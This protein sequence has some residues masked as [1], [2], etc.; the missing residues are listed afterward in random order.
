M[1]VVRIVN[2]DGRHG[3]DTF[4]FAR[5]VLS[6]LAAGALTPNSSAAAVATA[7]SRRDADRRTE[8][9][10][11][12]SSK[13]VFSEIPTLA[14]KESGWSMGSNQSNPTS[15]FRDSKGSTSM[16][17]PKSVGKGGPR[18]PVPFSTTVK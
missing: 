3:L 4:T 6:S 16:V 17:R 7:I 14:L 5:F 11:G 9:T 8:W 13:S 18:L 2:G 10:A 1:A 15:M 12:D